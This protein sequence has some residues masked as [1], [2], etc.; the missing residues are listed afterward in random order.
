MEDKGQHCATRWPARL[1]LSASLSSFRSKELDTKTDIMIGT[2]NPPQLLLTSLEGL[3][4]TSEEGNLNSNTTYKYQSLSP[5]F[6]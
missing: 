2:A 3:E 1:I 6:L 4:Q 5:C